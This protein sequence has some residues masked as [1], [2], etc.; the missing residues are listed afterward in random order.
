[1]LLKPRLPATLRVL[2]RGW[3]SSNNTL[4]FDGDK[5]T[6]VDSGYVTH[7]TQTLALIDHALEGRQLT[8]IINTHAHS[9]HIGGN[10]AIKQ[11]HGCRISVPAGSAQTLGEWD[12][13]ALLISSAAQ[14]ITRFEFDDTIAAGDEVT[15]GN[16]VWRAIAAPGHEAHALVFYAPQEKLLISGDALWEDGFGII[17][18]ALLGDTDAMPA[19]RRTLEMLATLDVHTVIPGHGAPFA[20]YPSAITRALQRMAAFEASPERLARH[21]LKALFA[22]TLLERR[23]MGLTDAYAHF[24]NTPLFRYVMSRFFTQEPEEVVML[25]LNDLVRARV[26][27][28]QDGDIVALQA[29]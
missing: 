12:E 17:F 29:N 23:R 2:E 11:Q 4:L 10:A 6:L 9:D 24:S 21:A 26:L 16:M 5:A 7:A 19:T 20:D 14:Q 25:L 28:E 15:M 18:R 22:F 1:M 3:L 13:D 8:R 27:G